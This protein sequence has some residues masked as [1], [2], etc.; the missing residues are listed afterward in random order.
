MSFAPL[1]ALVLMAGDSSG[2]IKF[3]LVLGMGSVVLIGLS[4]VLRKDASSVERDINDAMADSERHTHQLL[5]EMRGE[6]RH[7]SKAVESGPAARGYEVGPAASPAELHGRERRG[8]SHSGE[9]ENRYVSPPRSETG[10]YA[11]PPR[12]VE[13]DYESAGHDGAYQSRNAHSGRESARRRD[14]DTDGVRRRGTDDDVDGLLS[15]LRGGSDAEWRHERNPRT[16]PRGRAAADPDEYDYGEPQGRR[17]AYE[18]DTGS[19]RRAAAAEPRWR[20]EE[21]EVEVRMRQSRTG[22]DDGWGDD[23]YAAGSGAGRESGGW[24]EDFTSSRRSRRHA[25]D[26][27]DDPRY[28]EPT[29]AISADEADPQP[30][31]SDYDRPPPSSSRRGGSYMDEYYGDQEPRRRR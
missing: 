30:R 21:R 24:S 23:A 28:A 9:I 2:V 19:R 6:I 13:G 4:V 12:V 10:G 8:R 15:G 5:A 3:A 1:A 27:Y 7:L 17:E 25:D 14:P 20:T 16:P 18:E 22:P 31:W 26:A 29:R 11:S